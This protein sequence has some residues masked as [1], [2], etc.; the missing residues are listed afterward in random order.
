M[1]FGKGWQSIL[2]MFAWGQPRGV[3]ELFMRGFPQLVQ[4]SLVR[5]SLAICK[6]I[7]Y[8]KKCWQSNAR[9]EVTILPGQGN[10]VV[11]RVD[12]YST[13]TRATG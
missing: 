7:M 8:K 3:C 12:V 5:F 2:T 4:S 11:G 1:A 13:S 6:M 9:P 10:Q